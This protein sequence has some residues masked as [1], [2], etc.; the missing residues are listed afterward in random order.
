MS[1]KAHA[2]ST[3]ARSWTQQGT[4][5]AGRGVRCWE[6]R[7]LPMVTGT[8]GA[9][10]EG[11]PHVPAVPPG[12]SVCL[13]RSPRPWEAHRGLEMPHAKGPG[14]KR[15][16]RRLK[17]RCWVL[18]AGGSSLGSAPAAQH[19][20]GLAAEA[21]GL[22]RPPSRGFPTATRPKLLA[23]RILGGSRIWPLKGSEQK[24]KVLLFGLP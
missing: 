13:T 24:C 15:R 8:S 10:L 4:Q 1:P 12:A 17:R 23:K 3:G 21:R 2:H 5:R 11:D 14:T 6:A 16:G 7:S 19:P 18:G 9:E 20:H 22:C